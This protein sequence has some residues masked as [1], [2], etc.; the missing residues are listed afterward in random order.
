LYKQWVNNA[1]LSP[2]DLPPEM[3]KETEELAEGDDTMADV[4]GHRRELRSGTGL[5]FDNLL[6]S[7]SMRF[8]GIMALIIIVLLVALSVITTV[9]IMRSC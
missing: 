9:L 6:T 7:R 1:G 2:D 5:P 4:S 3:K 8:I